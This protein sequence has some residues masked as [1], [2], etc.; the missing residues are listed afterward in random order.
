MI[1][2]FEFSTLGSENTFYQ[3]IATRRAFGI[4]RQTR[5]TRINGKNCGAIQFAPP[6]FTIKNQIGSN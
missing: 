3:L 4:L 5:S 6:V 2:F 1:N